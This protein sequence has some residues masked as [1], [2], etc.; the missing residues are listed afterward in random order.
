MSDLNDPR[1]LFAWNRTA[2]GLIALGFFIDR[3]SLMTDAAETGALATSIGIAFIL[4]AVVLNVLSVVQYRRSVGALRTVEIPPRYWLNLAVFT[5]VVVSFL[6][7]L[8][9]LYIVRTL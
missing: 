3:A 8:L 2:S 6:G 7:L 9:V 4:L 1:V 5:N